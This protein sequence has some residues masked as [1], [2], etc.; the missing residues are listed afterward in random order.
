M[1]TLKYLT[2]QEASV[3]LGVSPTTLAKW[4]QLGRVHAFKTPGG[5]WRFREEDLGE[6]L[7]PV[8]ADRKGH[9][10]SQGEASG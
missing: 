9:G 2:L 7:S 10:G 1:G 5:R 4:A 3:L 8:Q 6:A